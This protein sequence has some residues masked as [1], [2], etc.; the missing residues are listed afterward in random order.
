MSIT[1]SRDR[2]IQS[3]IQQIQHNPSTT[4]TIA[5]TKSP[6]PEGCD[7]IRRTKPKYVVNPQ[8]CRDLPPHFT[9]TVSASAA[10]GMQ[11]AL[12]GLNIFG[13]TSP[14]YLKVHLSD[15]STVRIEEILSN[16]DSP[17]L[18]PERSTK[19]PWRLKVIVG[20][21][22]FLDD[23]FEDPFSVMQ[24]VDAVLDWTGLNPNTL[25]TYTITDKNGQRYGASEL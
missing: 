16:E 9:V 6:F 8:A 3:L 23:Y 11:Y 10:F 1:A 19:T 22:K 25:L 17:V 24:G 18:S 20:Y 15:G 13:S 7:Y 12:Y 21:D 2:E 5:V 14:V 4:L